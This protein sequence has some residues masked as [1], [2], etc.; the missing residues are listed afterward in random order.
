VAARFH[1]ASTAVYGAV[2][3]VDVDHRD[4]RAP[5]CGGGG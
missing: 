4:A 2:A 5:R 3:V 1:L